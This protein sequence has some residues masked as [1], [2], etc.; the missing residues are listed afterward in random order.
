MGRGH[1]LVIRVQPELLLDLL[2]GHVEDLGGQVHLLAVGAR[3]GRHQLGRDELVLARQ[4][5]ERVGP[6]RQHVLCVELVASGGGLGA[7]GHHPVFL[8]LGVCLEP[9]QLLRPLLPE[10]ARVEGQKDRVAEDLLQ[11]DRVDAGVRALQ[12]VAGSGGQHAVFAGHG[13]GQVLVQ[14]GGKLRLGLGGLGHAGRLD[15]VH[16]PG[17]G[18][19]GGGA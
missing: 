14:L 17:R 8:N 4:K 11:V 5:R 9:R 12:P 10:V 2:D 3:L 19:G 16:L 13:H 6:A 7:D 15:H 1:E 18:E